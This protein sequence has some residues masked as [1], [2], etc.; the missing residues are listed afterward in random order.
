[1]ARSLPSDKGIYF[2][3]S[4]LVNS[5]SIWAHGVPWDLVNGGNRTA[6]LRTLAKSAP[7][8]GVILCSIAVWALGDFHQEPAHWAGVLLHNHGDARSQTKL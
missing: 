1:M 4:R 3:R 8:A 2:R 6:E 5:W 7:F